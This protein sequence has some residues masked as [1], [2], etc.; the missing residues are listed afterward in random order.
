MV[1][2]GGSDSRFAGK[3]TKMT[4]AGR[5]LATLILAL[6][7]ALAGVANLV[8]VLQF[9]D[10]LNVGE[11]PSFWGG[12]WAG[13]FL[14]GVA[15]AVS[16]IV[17]YGWLTLQ[18]WA[19]MITLL[20]A[21]LAISVPFSSLIAGTETWSTALIPLVLSTAVLILALLSAVRQAVKTGPQKKVPAVRRTPALHPD[22]V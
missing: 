6:V 22:E 5:P 11:D 3:D 1:C 18:P 19:L 8:L 10:V 7:A 21:A 16:F 2:C 9:L 15:S 13:V 14:F 12:K 4:I 17:A 20:M